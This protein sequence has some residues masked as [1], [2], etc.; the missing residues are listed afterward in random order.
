MGEAVAGDG[1]DGPA[2][3]RR[4]VP[5]VARIAAEVAEDVRDGDLGVHR[6]GGTPLRAGGGGRFGVHEDERIGSCTK[7]GESGGDGR[8]GRQGEH[9]R[10]ADA[11]V[12]DDVGQE[13]RRHERARS[14]IAERMG[15]VSD[16]LREENGS[17]ALS[18]GQQELVD[19]VR[20]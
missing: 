18:V 9:P 16:A 1:R 11:E 8:G 19:A 15:N 12:G 7:R 3:R 4:G 2:E 14:S 20:V 6:G 17:D 5:E 13:G 10:L